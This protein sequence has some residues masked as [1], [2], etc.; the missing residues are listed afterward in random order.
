MERTGGWNTIMWSEHQSN[1]Q[2]HNPKEWSIGD[3]AFEFGN[4][5][6]DVGRRK[7]KTKAQVESV[8]MPC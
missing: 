7:Q 2:A 5:E 4:G 1:K 6:V 3:E 8:K